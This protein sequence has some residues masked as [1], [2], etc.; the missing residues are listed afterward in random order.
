MSLETDL[1]IWANAS[2]W[3][4]EDDSE[5][6]ITDIEYN[7]DPENIVPGEY[8]VTFKTEGYQYKVDTTDEYHEGDIV[9]LMFS[10]EDIHIMS[11]GSY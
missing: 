6:K 7:F 10:P 8:Y 4:L 11:K 2:A 1:K 3:S 5:V 9:G